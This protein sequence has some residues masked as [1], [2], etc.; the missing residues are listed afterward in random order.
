MEQRRNSGN[1]TSGNR[2]MK[3]LIGFNII[4]FAITLFVVMVL[5]YDVE[6]KD[7]AMILVLMPV[8]VGL[9]SIGAFLMTEG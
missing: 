2:I 4:A 3:Y 6:T 9:I 5:G 8:F 1:R 7:K